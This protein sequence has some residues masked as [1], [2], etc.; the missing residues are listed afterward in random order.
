VYSRNLL[1]LI[2]SQTLGLAGVSAVVLL[3]GIIGSELAPS[4]ALAT[5]PS[6]VMVI[7]TA[8]S[9]IPASALMSR[10][11]RRAGFIVG[12]LIA[13]GAG[14]LA[15]FAI[16]LGSFSLFCAAVLLIG[17]NSAFMQQYRFAATESVAAKY[18]GQ[19]VSLV[20]IGGIAAGYVGTEVAR[21]TS[22]L[23]PW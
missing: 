8:L 11:G 15:V 17:V 22:G 14:V 13:I 5:L 4:P 19:A 20:L 3:G 21:L 10:V 23:L 1:I 2:L 7:G 12:A 16:R 6:S 18:A 9:T